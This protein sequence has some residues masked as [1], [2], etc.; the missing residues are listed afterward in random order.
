M[1]ERI[2]LVG[3]RNKHVRTGMGTAFEMLIE[4]L[5]EAG[6]RVSIVNTKWGGNVRSAGSLDLKRV[7]V[8]STCVVFAYLKLFR[9]QTLYMPISTSRLG[10][11]RDSLII[12]FASLLKRRIVVHLHGSGLKPFYNQSSAKLQSSIRKT[13][14][15]IDCYIVLGELLRDQFDFVSQWQE[16]TVVVPNGTPIDESSIPHAFVKSAP[17]T[18]KPW[19]FLYLSNLMSTKGYRELLAACNNLIEQGYGNFHCDFCG[20]FLSSVA[21]GNNDPNNVRKEEFLAEINSSPLNNHVSYHGT[22]GG[23]K[24]DL[25]LKE[26]H[27]FLLPTYYPWEGQPLS[28]NEALAWSTPIV[29]TYHRGIPEQVQEGKNGYFVSPKDSDALAECMA[30][31]LSGEV[32]YQALSQYARKHY[33]ENFTNAKHLN[34]MISLLR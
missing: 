7:I 10:F 22:V 27:V 3:T 30:K 15:K 13:Y 24:K 4:G 29:T 28:I 21:E 31:F 9:C 32:P 16:K 23:E 11:Y 26:A 20:E 5:K 33:E 19:R 12:C 25:L 14:E 2:L 6:I 34:K 8:I 1:Q 18:D 17:S